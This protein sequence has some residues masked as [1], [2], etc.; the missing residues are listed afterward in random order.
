MGYV[1]KLTGE[2]LEF[3]TQWTENPNVGLITVFGPSKTA[4]TDYEPIRHMVERVKKGEI[5][6]LGNFDDDL[7]ENEIDNDKIPLNFADPE[8]IFEDLTDADYVKEYAKVLA[9]ET[10]GRSADNNEAHKASEKVQESGRGQASD[11]GANAN[12]DAIGEA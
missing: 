4:T 12:D 2:V 5:H 7:T 3:K 6:L 9:A 8:E 11:E 1:N 10:S